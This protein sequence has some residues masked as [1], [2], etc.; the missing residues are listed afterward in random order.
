[1]KLPANTSLQRTRLSDEVPGTSEVN[2]F[3]GL[4]LSEELYG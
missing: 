4:R 2:D 3:S 1:M